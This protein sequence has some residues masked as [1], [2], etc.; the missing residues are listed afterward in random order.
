MQKSTQSDSRFAANVA[1]GYFLLG[2]TGVFDSLGDTWYPNNYVHGYV[3]LNAM[4]ILLIGV[5]LLAYWNRQAWDAILFIGG[6]IGAWT[7]QAAAS[8]A[9]PGAKG[10]DLSRP[11]SEPISYEGW[12]FFVQGVFFFIL[13]TAALKVD[14]L[15]QAFVVIK[16]IEFLAAG[17]A[18]WF[19]IAFLQPVCGYLGMLSG[20]FGATIATLALR[21]LAQ[22]QDPN[23][24]T[25]DDRR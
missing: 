2:A 9:N 6:G 18:C 10:L 14:R 25:I 5:G 7:Y 15:R 19:G 13:V 11:P 1:L 24:P 12:Y 17:V 20:I 16:A 3:L 4:G 22:V 21:E 23:L 8:M